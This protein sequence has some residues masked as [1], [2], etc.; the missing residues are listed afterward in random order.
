MQDEFP[1]AKNVCYLNTA[2]DGILPQSTLH[3][4]HSAAVKKKTPQE[5]GEEEFYRRPA[6]CR[7]LI[8]AMLHCNPEEIAL[9]PSTQFGLAAVAHSLP[10]TPRDEVLIVE[11]DFPSNNFT[12]EGLRADGV[13]IREV[14]FS[15]DGGHMARLMEAIRPATRV[16]SVSLVH[17][18]TGYLYDLPLLSAHCSRN[19]IFLVLDAIQA[20]GNM[21]LNLQET[22][23]TA[24]SAAAHKWQLSPQG[25]GFLYVNRDVMPQ[26]KPS[27]SGWMHNRD[28]AT[29]AE[30]DFFN[31]GTPQ[32]AWRFELGTV[33][34]MLTAGYEQS[35][36][37]LLRCRP[38]Y[39]ERHNARLTDRL[40]GF[41][42]EIG[43]PVSDS[44]RSASIFC[45]RPPARYNPED[46]VRKLREREVFVSVRNQY[47][48]ISPHF[49][50]SE[51][52]IDRFCEE[53]RKLI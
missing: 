48:R 36:N 21:E 10:L 18:W 26:L 50:N 43:W 16:I 32:A 13:T 39:I 4:M 31:Y 38:P 44:P 1:N 35:L 19:G 23:V 9:C 45:V 33:P 7:E 22:T 47:L 24:V 37:I 6:R 8:A 30:L 41:F 2:A 5:L 49:Y 11:R 34:Y 20:A 28:S 15:P 29:F 17:F 42:R 12:W 51:Q 25:T 3:A 52:D 53:L 14:P 40:A 27:L 46:L